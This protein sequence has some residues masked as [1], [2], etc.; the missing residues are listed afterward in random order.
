VNFEVNEHMNFRKGTRHKR[1]HQL[2]MKYPP[3][4]LENIKVVSNSKQ[5]MKTENK[6]K[7]KGGFCGGYRHAFSSSNPTPRTTDEPPVFCDAQLSLTRAYFGFLKS[8]APL[9][10][11]TNSKPAS[12]SILASFTLLATLQ[13]L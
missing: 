7:R 9:N 6:P 2:P 13:I 11:H 8:F 12:I 4:I 1:H 3:P 10:S 5:Q